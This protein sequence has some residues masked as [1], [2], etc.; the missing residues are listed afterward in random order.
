MSHRHRIPTVLFFSV[1]SSLIVFT[2]SAPPY[3]SLLVP[4]VVNYFSNLPASV[5]VS[6]VV[7]PSPPRSQWIPA[8]YFIYSIITFCLSV[9]TKWTLFYKYCANKIHSFISFSAFIIFEFGSRCLAHSLHPS[10]FTGMFI[11]RKQLNHAGN[12][13]KKGIFLLYRLWSRRDEY[14]KILMNSTLVIKKLRCCSLNCTK[15]NSKHSLEMF[16]IDTT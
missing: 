10:L 14:W 6:V 4:S 15:L 13:I 5:A 7:C 16:R 2:L 9:R 1:I 11:A 12:A 3:S 8:C